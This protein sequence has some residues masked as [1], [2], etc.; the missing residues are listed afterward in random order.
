MDI[1]K[2]K[3][4]LQIDEYFLEILKY[5][6][7]HNDFWCGYFLAT[8]QEEVIK[9]YNNSFITLEESNTLCRCGNYAS[10]NL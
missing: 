4:F 2:E 5:K 3:Q 10:I 6:R 9:A 1:L 8:F 7:E